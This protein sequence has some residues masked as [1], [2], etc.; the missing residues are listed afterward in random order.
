[1]SVF[2]ISELLAT[3]IFGNENSSLEQFMKSTRFQNSNLRLSCLLSSSLTTTQF[4]GYV[5][6]LRMSCIKHNFGTKKGRSTGKMDRIRPGKAPGRPAYTPWA[7]RP[8]PLWPRLGL[9]KFREPL[10]RFAYLCFIES[11]LW[12]GL[13]KRKKIREKE[14]KKK[15]YEKKRINEGILWLEKCKEISPCCLR[16][17]SSIPTMCNP[18]TRTMLV[19][20]SQSFCMPLHM[21][22]IL[23]LLTLEPLTLWR[24][25]HD[26]WLGR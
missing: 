15:M 19:P 8:R 4:W 11:V 12:K 24:N 1:M 6:F 21:S 25:S 18:T 13:E 14:R 16:T 3:S 22:T 2:F 23:N 5:L 7:G 10:R 26:H 9:Q 20:W 17:I